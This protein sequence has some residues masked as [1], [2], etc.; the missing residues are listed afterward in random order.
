MVDGVVDVAHAKG[1]GGLVPLGMEEACGMLLVYAQD[2]LVHHIEPHLLRLVALVDDAYLVVFLGLVASHEEAH[3]DAEGVVVGV[4][5]RPALTVARSGGDE[6][7]AVPSAGICSAGVAFADEEHLAGIVAHDVVAPAGE[8]ELLRVVGEGEACHRGADDTAEVLL[9]SNDVDPRHGGV[10]V[11]DHIVAAVI[12]EAAILIIVSQVAP[13]AK[14]LAGLQDG[15]FYLVLI[16]LVGHL[17]AAQLLGDGYT[18]GGVEGEACHRA[19][20]YALGIGDV[21]AIEHKDLA[22]GRMFGP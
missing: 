8:L 5:G 14:F 21:A 7:T 2:E 11:G 9:I 22:S 16:V 4:E 19:E 15:I 17:E 20:Q 3:G 6:L 10:G 18:V 1:V 12:V 13:H